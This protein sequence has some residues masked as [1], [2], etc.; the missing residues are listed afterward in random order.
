MDRDGGIDSLLSRWAAAVEAKDV[1]TLVELVEEDA[2]FWANGAPP[3]AGRQ[4]VRTAFGVFFS[5]FDTRQ[6]FELIELLID[7]DLA[8]ARG[9][10]HNHLTPLDGSD[11]VIHDQ[12][13]FS[14]MRRGGD[15]RWRFSRGMTNLPPAAE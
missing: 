5:R 11:A 2:E 3:L 15:G 7:G 8:V 12:R 14:V 1:D 13:A 9:I 4:A 6:E 10:E